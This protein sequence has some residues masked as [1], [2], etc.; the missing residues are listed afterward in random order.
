MT[1]FDVNYILHFI[2][3]IITAKCCF[4]SF[5]QSGHLHYAHLE[6]ERII[7]FSMVLAIVENE[8]W[9]TSKSGSLVIALI[10]ISFSRVYRKTHG[11][12]TSSTPS[13]DIANI[14]CSSEFVPATLSTTII[15]AAPAFWPLRAF[16]MNVQSP[17]STTNMRSWTFSFGVFNDE[18]SLRG[19]ARLTLRWIDS[20]PVSSLEKCDGPA[21]KSSIPPVPPFLKKT[22]CSSEI[23]VAIWDFDNSTISFKNWRPLSASSGVFACF[24]NSNF[25]NNF[26][27]S[28]YCF[29]A[30]FATHRIKTVHQLHFSISHRN[31]RYSHIRH[32]ATMFCIAGLF[33]WKLNSFLETILLPNTRHC[34]LWIQVH[35][36][37]LH[38]S[39][40]DIHR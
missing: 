16:S 37:V 39:C 24:Q 27:S 5:F 35:L 31:H 11:I 14:G 34:L 20:L 6:F 38:W 25:N 36:F 13:P 21:N 3:F 28:C 4:Q 33:V 17:R 26:R 1:T 18:H 9:H 19:S 10:R 2:I 40:E 32:R 15:A 30:A 7:Y 12:F 8:F 29:A 23:D 22:A